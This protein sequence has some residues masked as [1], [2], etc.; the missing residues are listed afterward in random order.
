MLARVQSTAA[1]QPRKRQS[2]HI[3]VRAQA[4]KAQ[5]KTSTMGANTEQQ[6]Q[7]LTMKAR[8][9]AI[10]YAIQYHDAAA[11]HVLQRYEKALASMTLDSV[12]RLFPGSAWQ[13]FQANGW[14]QLSCGLQAREL[15]MMKI[16]ERSMLAEI[17]ADPTNPETFANAWAASCYGKTWGWYKGHS[18]ANLYTTTHPIQYCLWVGLYARLLLKEGYEDSRENVKAVI[19]LRLQVYNHK[20]QLPHEASG[21]RFADFDWKRTNGKTP[22]PQG[23]VATSPSHVG[24]FERWRARFYDLGPSHEVIVC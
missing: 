9:L 20:I 5:L 14:A 10:P 23:L 3:D 15:R 13:Q 21:N 8:G 24:N 7:L 2:F 18:A 16:I 11:D 12:A 19:K 22:A 6:L 4:A 17:G 1:V